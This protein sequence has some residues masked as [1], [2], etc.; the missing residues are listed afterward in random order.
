[1]KRKQVTN[2]VLMKVIEGLVQQVGQ[3]LEKHGEGAFASPHEALGV[4]AEENWELIEAIKSNDPYRTAEEWYDNAVTCV[5]AIASM[6]A[7]SSVDST[8]DDEVSVEKVDVEDAAERARQL[9]IDRAE[10][11]GLIIASDI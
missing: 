1:M 2:E 3:R 8:D 9:M 11:S 10:K 6:A 7:S 5:F 4:L